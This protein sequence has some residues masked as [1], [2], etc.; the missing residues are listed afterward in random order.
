MENR[1]MA[2]KTATET[3]EHVGAKNGHVAATK[4]RVNPNLV[5]LKVSLFLIFGATSSLVPYLTVHMQ[6][7]GLTVAEI[8]TVYLTL[9]GTTCLS[10]PITGYLVD[11]FGRYKPVLLVALV[12]NIVSHH[13]L[14]HFVPR[15]AMTELRTVVAKEYGG[16][17]AGREFAV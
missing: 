8:A 14:D 9:L 11:R 15:R 10:P 2:P 6:S 5:L 17:V 3:D 4:R 16:N 7:L 1:K 13:A 12:L